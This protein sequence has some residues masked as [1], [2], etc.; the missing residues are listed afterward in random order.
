MDTKDKLEKLDEKMEQMEMRHEQRHME[1]L[2]L[3]ESLKANGPVA[4]SS[5][6]VESSQLPSERLET[7]IP[8][9]PEQPSVESAASLSTSTELQTLS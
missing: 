7:R 5:P 9:P 8:I 1:I 4:S 3:L 6:Q 2:I